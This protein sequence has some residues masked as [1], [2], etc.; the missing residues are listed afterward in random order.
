MLAKVRARAH[1][2]EMLRAA[3]NALA[4][5]VADVLRSRSVRCSVGC[6]GHAGGKVCE[7]CAR[8]N[9]YAGEVRDADLGG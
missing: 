8:A 9:G 1:A 2:L 6:K 7:A 5:A 3:R 4:C